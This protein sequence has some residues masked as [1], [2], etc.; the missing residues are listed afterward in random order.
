MCPVAQYIFWSLLSFLFAHVLIKSKN[1]C[2]VC[3]TH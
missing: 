1:A 3:D 2:S